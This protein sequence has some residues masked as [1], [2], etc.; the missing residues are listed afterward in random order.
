MK[1]DDVKRALLDADNNPFQVA[2]Y[3][4]EK[5]EMTSGDVGGYWTGM[6]TEAVLADFVSYK[7]EVYGLHLT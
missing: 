5:S 4:E 2:D 3:L 6:D 7:T 1:P